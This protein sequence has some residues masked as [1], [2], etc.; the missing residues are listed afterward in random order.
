MSDL[1]VKTGATFA[2]DRILR[3]TLTREWGPGPRACYIG[4][5]PSDAAEDKEDPTSHLFRHFATVNGFGSYVTVNLYPRISSDPKQCRAWAN[6]EAN[7]PDWAARDD[8][9]H[10]ADIV[11]REAKAADRVVACWGALAQ[12][13]LWVEHII[14]AIQFGDGP[15]PSIYCLGKTISGAPKHPLARGHHRIAR[16][17]RF[18]VWRAARS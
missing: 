16:D 3:L 17:Q 8:L 6:W 10:N 7:G 13:D 18:T 2:R 9:Q 4:H 5:N 12:D 11:A 1:L 15:W 14:E